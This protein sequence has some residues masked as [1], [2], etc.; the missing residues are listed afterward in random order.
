M[1]SAAASHGRGLDQLGS[2]GGWFLSVDRL[3]RGS[4][5]NAILSE[6]NSSTAK[7]VPGNQALFS[8]YG[9]MHFGFW[10]NAEHAAFRI[11]QVFRED[12][13]AEYNRFAFQCFSTRLVRKKQDRRL[14]II[15]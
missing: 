3:A 14:Q 2:G 1:F 5:L 15:S 12:G 13:R 7:R 10:S 4:F 11:L 9:R 6:S 8:L